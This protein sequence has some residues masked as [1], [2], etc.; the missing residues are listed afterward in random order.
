MF[1]SLFATIC[2]AVS[3]VSPS[4]VST[5]CLVSLPPL[6]ALAAFAEPVCLV[7]LPAGAWPVFPTPSPPVN[8]PTPPPT[9]DGSDPL[10]APRGSLL[11]ALNQPLR[12]CRLGR[13]EKQDDNGSNRKM[14]SQP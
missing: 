3:C 12:I 10:V 11:N 7:P 4:C 13:A 6:P 9:A 2:S 5:A 14:Q 8:T 1:A